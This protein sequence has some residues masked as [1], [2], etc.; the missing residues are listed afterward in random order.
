MGM[1]SETRHLIHALQDDTNVFLPFYLQNHVR[2]VGKINTY[3]NWK[4]QTIF[5]T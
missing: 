3:P 4:L 2:P 5:K 1:I